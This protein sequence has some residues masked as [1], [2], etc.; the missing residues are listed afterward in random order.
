M[1]MLARPWWNTNKAVLLICQKPPE[2]TVDAQVIG[3]SPGGSI[4]ELDL[5]VTTFTRTPDVNWKRPILSGDVMVRIPLL[6]P[7]WPICHQHSGSKVD[8]HCWCQGDPGLPPISKSMNGTHD[9]SGELEPSQTQG[10]RMVRENVVPPQERLEVP[11]V[12][13]C[14]N[15]GSCGLIHMRNDE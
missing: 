13:L 11:W 8:S 5:L 3:I 2:C 7:Y 4:W 10:Q 9:W 15:C 12:R 14:D 6:G 1:G